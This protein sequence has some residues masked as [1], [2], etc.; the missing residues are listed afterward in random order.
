[1]RPQ[2]WV[3]SCLVRVEV[4]RPPRPPS[5][6]SNLTTSKAS[7]LSHKQ[8]QSTNQK[9]LSLAW[10]LLAARDIQSDVLSVLKRISRFTVDNPTHTLWNLSD[11]D[12]IFCYGQLNH[13]RRL[14]ERAMHS[15]MDGQNFAPKVP[16]YMYFNRIFEF[17]DLL[18]CLQMGIRTLSRLEA[19]GLCVSSGSRSVIC[20]LLVRAEIRRLPPSAPRLCVHF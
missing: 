13:F 15:C 17:E 3:S 7:F 16:Q 5:P 18:E 6:L 11:H 20:P 12:V 9:C 8:L 14:C 4:V 2:S 1:M 10:K 19:S